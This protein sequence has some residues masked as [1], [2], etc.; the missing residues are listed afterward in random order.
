MD[1]ETAQALAARWRPELAA[2]PARLHIDGW[3]VWALEVGDWIVRIPRRP[4]IV[5]E[6]LQ[7]IR[8]LDAAGTQARVAATAERVRAQVVP[9]LAREAADRADREWGEI[10]AAVAG[11]EF[12]PAVVHG[13]LYAANVLVDRSRQVLTGVID[14]TSLHVGDPATDFA[15]LVTD[16]GPAVAAELADLYADDTGVAAGLLARAATYAQLEPYA[17]VL[18]GLERD[19][20]EHVRDGLQKIAAGG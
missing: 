20:D 17:E 4:E 16:L 2:A 12:E 14:W 13:D 19:A 3:N 6:L 5:D 11:F 18:F 9:L 1:L 7:E 10:L 15:G 8:L